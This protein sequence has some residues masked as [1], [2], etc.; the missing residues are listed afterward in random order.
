MTD[1]QPVPAT[2]LLGNHLI[3]LAAI[4]SNPSI[5]IR[6]LSQVLDLTERSTQRVVNELEGAGLI[7]VSRAGRRNLYTVCDGVDLNLP[8][9]R[10][11]P[12]DKV[13]RALSV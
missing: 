12:V 10:R 11:I 5:L 7:R 8:G 3:A 6:E 4:R 13:L 2:L 1:R 9:G